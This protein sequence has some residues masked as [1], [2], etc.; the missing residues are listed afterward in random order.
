[1]SNFQKSFGWIIVTILGS[2]LFAFGFS[3]F[4]MPND[5]STGG[6]SGL[7]LVAVELLGGTRW[8]VMTKVIWPGS[9]PWLLTSLRT[10]LG[11]SISGA[12]VGE[13]LGA[14]KGMGWVLAAASQRYDVSRVLCCVAVIICIV[15][16]LD[17]VVRLLEHR[18]LRWR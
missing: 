5:I 17:G 10:G 11:L 8:Q 3:C 13:Y 9:L 14:G 7:A 4:L 16:L 6:I 15:V 1:M 12:I 18:L 2:A